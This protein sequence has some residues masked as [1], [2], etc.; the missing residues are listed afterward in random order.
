M[1]ETRPITIAEAA[2]R[3]TGA[4]ESSIRN[5]LKRGQLPSV[6]VGG[7]IH[8]PVEALRQMYGILYKEN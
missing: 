8:V 1:T 5:K 4:T 6:V 7:R 2:K 3:I